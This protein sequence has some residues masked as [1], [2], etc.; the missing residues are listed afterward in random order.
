MH[1]HTLWC[2]LL[3][4]LSV[5]SAATTPNGTEGIDLFEVHLPVN[6]KAA[7]ADGVRFVYIKVGELNQ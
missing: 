6:W 5:S 1:I 4:L 7:V 3:G 2:L